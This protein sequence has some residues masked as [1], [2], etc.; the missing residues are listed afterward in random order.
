MTKRTKLLQ[1]TFFLACLNSCDASNTSDDKSTGS[2]SSTHEAKTQQPAADITPVKAPVQAVKQERNGACLTEADLPQIDTFM[3]KWKA[4]GEENELEV[5]FTFVNFPLLDSYH[6]DQ[7]TE[8]NF[9]DL[10]Y[11]DAFDDELNGSYH[12]T[13]GL[14]E[15]TH[16]KCKLYKI[17]ARSEPEADPRFIYFLGY[18]N[19]K[20]MIM[21]FTD[22]G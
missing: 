10:D 13:K 19:G 1:I 3:Q 6:D 5:I 4:A 20:I 15:N 21:D 16:F 7:V 8:D 18:K 12:I 17:E 2:A 11:L 9:I 14:S 22:F